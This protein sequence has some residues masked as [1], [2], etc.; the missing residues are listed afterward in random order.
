MRALSPHRL[1]VA[2]AAASPPVQA[3]VYATVAA[4]AFSVMS[5][6]IRYTGTNL[7]PFEVVFFRNLISLLFMAPLLYRIGFSGLHKDRIGLHAVRAS[8]S[9]GS[10][11]CGFTAVTLIP[12][13]ESTALS[14]A[15]PLF[16]TA[17]AALFLGETVRMRRWSAVIIGFAGTLIILQPAPD[18]MSFGSWLALANSLLIG[19]GYLLVKSLSRTERPEEIVGYMVLLLTPMSLIPAIFVWQWPSLELVLAMVALGAVGTIGHLYLTRAFQVADVTIAMPFDF[20]R[21]PFT[22]AIAFMV[23][24]EVP[25]VWTWVGGAVIFASTFYIAR[26]EAQLARERAAKEQAP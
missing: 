9:L 7:H 1:T 6:L 5:T 13:T 20:F 23:Y 12:L 10:M 21:L 25:T 18:S 8:L 17:G 2:F 14:F 11:L 24:G 19:I 26:R 4:V 15:A 22:A 3:G 16:S